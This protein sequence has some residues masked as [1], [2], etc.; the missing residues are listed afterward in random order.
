MAGT[1]V[2]KAG[3]REPAR[4][5]GRHGLH[6]SNT[7]AAIA[8]DASH[9]TVAVSVHEGQADLGYL[10]RIVF[11]SFEAGASIGTKAANKAVHSALRDAAADILRRAFADEFGKV[12]QAYRVMLRESL[13]KGSDPALRTALDRVRL[14]ER[15]L[16]ETSMVEQADAC[17]LLGLST[18]N[19]SATM[20]RKE[21]GNGILRFTIDGRAVYPLFQFDVEGRRIHP[22]MARLIASKPKGWSDFRL[23]H[24]LTRPHLDMDG[25]PAESLGTDP[26]AVLAAFGREIEPPVHG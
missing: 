24:W 23:L 25:T 15:L 13:V 6:A 22:S 10:R 2:R 9:V 14:Q 7:L 21:E 20:R 19:P 11:A 1:L 17:T 5:P 26:E 12:V 8:E 4:G 16:A 3:G 18:A